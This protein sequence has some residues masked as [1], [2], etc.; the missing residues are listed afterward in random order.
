[1]VE[2]CVGRGLS[3]WRHMCGI[4]GLI[5][6]RG[7][8][9][10][11]ERLRQGTRALDHRGPDDWGMEVLRDE[12]RGLTIGLGH[13]RLSIL[14]LSVAGHQPMR[15]EVTGDLIVYNGEVFNYRELRREMESA[16]TS[17][18]SGTDTEVVLS[19]F[20]ESGVE[21]IR[22]W[23]GMFA[24]GFWSR[25]D[26]RLTLVRDRLGIKPLYYYRGTD[27]FLFG[28]EVRALLA[29]GLVPRQVSAGAVESYLAYG[30]IQQPLTII[31]GLHAV[32]P[33]HL[34]EF[35]NEQVTTRAYWEVGCVVAEEG[36]AGEAGEAKDAVRVAEEIGELT[37]EAV[38]LRMVSDVPVG[39][40]LSG[41]IDSSAVV[42]LMRRASTS[43][44]HSFSVNF[45]GHDREREFD[46]REYAEEVARRY[47]TRHSSVIL[48]E[49]EMLGK[50]PQALRDLDQPSI[51][52]INTWIVSEAVAAA[53]MK[54]ALS[55][56]GGD[57]G[58]LGYGFLGTIERLEH[59]RGFLNRLPGQLRVAAG[60]AARHLAW[61]A[62][63]QRAAKL[64]AL[65]G[66]EPFEGP[67]VSLHRQ[68]FTKAQRR[69][70]RQAPDKDDRET[71]MLAEWT[72]RQQENCRGADLLN[73]T[74]ALEMGGYLANT[75]LR[76][77]DVMSMAHGLEVRVPLLDHLLIERLLQIPGSMKLR[78][79]EPKW[80]LVQAAGDL[81]PSIWQRPKR[82][83][84]LP[85]RL[86]LRG[87]LRE[88]VEGTLAERS[89][90]DLIDPAGAR[91][92]WHSFLEGQ[93]SWSR[94]W[95][96][97]VLADWCRT[98]LRG[99]L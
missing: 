89:L 37:C 54:V 4:I 25:R 60:A 85:F 95:A 88:R 39:V 53:G 19:G 23:R 52:G 43:E 36:E 33:G 9:E 82:G 71:V 17:F 91:A 78:S 57:E 93:T 14:D 70:L 66:S 84:E 79:G 76:D 63:G 73:Q 13:R 74:S 24:F 90:G 96:I 26:G 65:C 22:R 92:V 72:A 94:V 5:T 40:F 98:H 67:A 29:T 86:W 35:G 47:G 3:G 12:G 41:G 18:R 2:M 49:S 42:S 59:L 16:G 48:T 31:E 83:F 55:G 11:G 99:D 81:P 75:L 45:G 46:E 20:G 10:V 50:V 27:F 30:S 61:G 51:D 7:V 77:T 28:S 8:G 56:L 80:M 21:A 62:A 6:N 1:M 69:Q 97:V 32:L 58:F 38:R 87:A 34:V 44:I 15:N 64:E 68:L